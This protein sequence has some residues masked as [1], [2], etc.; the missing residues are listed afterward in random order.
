MIWLCL[1]ESIFKLKFIIHNNEA[2]NKKQKMLQRY[3]H[4]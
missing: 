1:V 3:E 4:S 2:V